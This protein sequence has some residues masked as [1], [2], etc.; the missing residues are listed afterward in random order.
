MLLTRPSYQGLILPLSALKQLLT[1]CRTHGVPL[2]VD[3]AHGAHLSLIEL[4]EHNSALSVGADVVV[5]SA[6]KSLN[7][8]SQ[9]GFLHRGRQSLIAEELLQSA[10]SM[11][12]T[13]S[14]NSLLLA[15]LDATQAYVGRHSTHYPL[16]ACCRSIS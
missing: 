6:H 8:L 13:T 9:A 10:H 2:I 12:T 4:E 7:A 15:S 5:Q 1:A 14:P 3:E 11:L 16:S